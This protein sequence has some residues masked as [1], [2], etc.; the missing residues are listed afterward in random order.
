MADD[1]HGRDPFDDE[2]T[3]FIGRGGDAGRGGWGSRDGDQPTEYI[4]RDDATRRIGGPADPGYD[5]DAD[6]RADDSTRFD[7][8]T[9]VGRAAAGGAAGGSGGPGDRGQYWAPLTPEE[10]AAAGYGDDARYDDS[11]RDGSAGGP[12]AEPPRRG[13][14]GGR[15]DDD[16]GRGGSG[17]RGAFIVAIVAIIA[18]VVLVALMFRFLSGGGDEGPTTTEAPPPEPTTQTQTPEE[19]TE[20]TTSTPGQDEIDRLRDEMSSL[21][22]N[23]PAIPGLPG[24]EV[25]EATVPDGLVGRSPAEAELQLRRAGFGEI[26]VLDAEGNPT[27]SLSS[28]TAT[29][30]SVDPPSGT[31]TSTDQQVTI[32]LR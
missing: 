12:P 25:R 3:R 20:P 22:E 31:V 8:G 16:S 14:R 26:T 6:F 1:R 18:V 28:L 13:G 11:Y 5:P 17:G 10:R 7:G 30:D 19:T 23:P 32:R 2:P 4:G 9:G 21:R 24:G 15:G 29:V 27:N